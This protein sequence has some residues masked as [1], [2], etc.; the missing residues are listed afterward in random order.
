ML[1]HIELLSQLKNIGLELWKTIMDLNFG[2]LFLTRILDLNFG[3]EFN[4]R[5]LDYNFGLQFWSRMSDKTTKLSYSM[6]ITFPK[7]IIGF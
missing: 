3:L 4:T 7:C 1:S 6:L 2:L 5:R